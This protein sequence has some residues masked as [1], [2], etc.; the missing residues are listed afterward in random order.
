MDS[1]STMKQFSS[2]QVVSA[3]TKRLIWSRKH[4]ST[5]VLFSSWWKV[6]STLQLYQPCNGFCH[7]IGCSC[8]CECCLPAVSR[9]TL[10]KVVKPWILY[11]DLVRYC[12]SKL[13][14]F[15]YS[16]MIKIYLKILYLE[17]ARQ[18]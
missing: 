9:S 2:I 17:K 15:Y 8:C 1:P 7:R 5:L 14:Y 18:M 3:I 4:Q 16:T 6:A 11:F 13:Y 12:H 10:A